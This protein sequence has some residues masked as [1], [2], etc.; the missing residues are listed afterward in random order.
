MK[1]FIGITGASGSIYGGRLVRALVAAG[2]E[3]TV[4]F[5]A[6]A[7]EVI[8]Q[9]EYD[10]GLELLGAGSEKVL[11][12]FFSR[13]DISP[14]AVEVALPDNIGHAYSSG[15]ALM[16]GAAVCPCSMST[17]ASIAAGITG[18]LIHRVAGVALKEARPLVVVP[19]EAPLSE[20]HLQNL[21]R[22][23]QAGGHVL[24]A[25]PAFYHNPQS[26]E[27]LVDFIAGKVLDLLGADH[28]LFKR[29]EGI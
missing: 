8:R 18:D 9:E 25:A 6:G 29:W 1:I 7:V 28:Q 11:E 26:I 19:R 2:H 23:R 12:A 15:T 16:D 20:I 4:C 17:A 3:T 21:L 22:I 5:S 27:D 13:H 10:A 14:Q 24:P